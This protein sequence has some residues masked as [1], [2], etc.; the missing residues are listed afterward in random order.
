MLNRRR[1]VGLPL[2]ETV[3]L[4]GGEGFPIRFGWLNAS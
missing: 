3:T 1:F 4:L 2:Y